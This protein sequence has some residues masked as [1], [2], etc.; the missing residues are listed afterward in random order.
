MVLHTDENQPVRRSTRLR[1]L[2]KNRFCRHMFCA[3]VLYSER[4]VAH[5]IYTLIIYIFISPNTGAVVSLLTGRFIGHYALRRNTSA[6]FQ[7]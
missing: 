2:E 1:R 5:R 7:D 6:A 4:H 3:T